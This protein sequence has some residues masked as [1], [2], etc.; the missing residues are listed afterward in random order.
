MHNK[1]YHL[2]I[3]Y[4]HRYSL[5]GSNN[6]CPP[7]STY[8]YVR[9]TRVCSNN[10]PC[11]FSSERGYYLGL[12]VVCAYHIIHAYTTKMWWSRQGFVEALPQKTH[13]SVCVLS[14]SSPLPRKSSR[15]FARNLACC[16]IPQ[17]PRYL[18]SLVSGIHLR[19]CTLGIPVSFT[20][21]ST[22]CLFMT[23]G[24]GWCVWFQDL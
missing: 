22:S 1:L 5:H 6:T 13:C 15:N 18:V 20:F 10:F 4:H 24:L 9:Y 2:D 12:P 19:V 16:Y 7:T 14:S 11:R 3:I 8:T 23:L 21:V 17:V